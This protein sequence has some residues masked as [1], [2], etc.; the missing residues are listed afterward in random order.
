MPPQATPVEIVT[1]WIAAANAQDVERLLQLSDPQIA[2][3]GP[4]GASTGHQPLRDWLTRA[5]LTLETR[6]A[7][8]RANTV[9]LDQRGVWRTPM[10]GE[11]SGERVLAS[12]FRTDT[13]RQRVVYFAR[14]DDLVAALQ[15]ADLDA[16]DAIA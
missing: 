4:R 8:A 13:D 1:A 3:A 5:G 6:R 2:I 16:T 14:F 12:L 10:S 7:F 15:A 11:I 9:V